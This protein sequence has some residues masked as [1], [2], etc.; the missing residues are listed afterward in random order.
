MSPRILAARRQLFLR[1]TTEVVVKG[2]TLYHGSPTTGLAEIRRTG[3]IHPQEHGILPGEW[4]C[5]SPNDNMLRCFSDGEDLNGMIFEPE[6]LRCLKLDWMHMALSSWESCADFEPDWLGKFPED[7]SLARRLG[8]SQHRGDL[9]IS[10]SDF[11][12]LIPEWV[13]GLIF[14]WTTICPFVG[15]SSSSW[16]DETEIALNERGCQ[17]IW[18]GLTQLAIR[19]EWEDNVKRGWRKILRNERKIAA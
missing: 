1:R 3:M 13:D 16:N 9:G 2:Q 11:R 4:F 7:E 10:E 8:Y 6:P 14:P 12:A 18:K 15:V 19:G 17:K 5:V